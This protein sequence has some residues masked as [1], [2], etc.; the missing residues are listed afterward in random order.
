MS[1]IELSHIF[2]YPVKSLAG[3]S[4]SSSVVT[5]SG[6]QYDRRWMIVNNKGLFITQRLH[7]KLSLI[8]TEIIGD[9]IRL[10][11]PDGNNLM[12]PLSLNQGDVASV[13]VW[14][15]HVDGIQASKTHND[16]ITDYLGID[17]R[18]IYMPETTHRPVD[19]SFSKSSLDSVSFA[20]GFPYLLIS[21]GSL[22]DLNKKLNHKNETSVSINRFRPNLVVSGCEPYVEDKWTEYNMGG[23]IFYNVKPCSR[24]IMTT[25]DATTGQKGIE[26]LKTLLEYRKTGNKAYFGQNVLIDLNYD[27]S[28]KVSVG[29]TVVLSDTD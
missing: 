3:I 8:H 13:R 24:C 6:L 23:N 29:D 26:P 15:D 18:F 14:S 22:N 9:Q 5:P 1:K 10:T 25:I 7:P 20:D 19:N 21:S 16:W 17:A 27:N 11:A 4:L 2:I 12:L 28:W